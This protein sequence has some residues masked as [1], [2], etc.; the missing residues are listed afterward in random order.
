MEARLNIYSDCSSEEPTK[1]YICRRLLYKTSK[2]IAALIERMK[3]AT[4][5]EQ[6]QITIDVI[7]T[8]FPDF[9][10]EEFGDID[11]T[12]WLNFV[13]QINNET[14]EILTNASKNF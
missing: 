11:P 1:V 2:K 10:T 9:K 5:E 4:P 7:K 14:N 3:E 12:E 13:N 8:I 6:E